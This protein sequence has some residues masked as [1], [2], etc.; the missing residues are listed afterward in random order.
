MKQDE[1]SAHGGSGG[2]GAA[3]PLPGHRVLNP[4]LYN[5]TAPDD[6]MKQQGS[7]L[8]II[9]NSKKALSR[10]QSPKPQSRQCIYY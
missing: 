8:M 5:M 9:R 3:A 10:S 1:P 4:E 7:L 2:S 6:N